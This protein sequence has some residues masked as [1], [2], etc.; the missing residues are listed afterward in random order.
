MEVGGQ[1]KQTFRFSKRIGRCLCWVWVD[2]VGEHASDH[3]DCGPYVV[4]VHRVLLRGFR[5]R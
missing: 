1:V 4:V 2:V 3:N 5:S